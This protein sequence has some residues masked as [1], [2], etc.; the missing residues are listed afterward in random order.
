MVVAS[1]LITCRIK[2][3][4]SKLYA[5]LTKQIYKKDH[6]FHRRLNNQ[7]FGRTHRWMAESYFHNMSSM[8][9]YN[10]MVYNKI[11]VGM[12]TAIS[13]QLEMKSNLI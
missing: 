1:L 3:L 10:Q 2:N 7:Y 8:S 5:T 12:R 6:G 13:T 11:Y 9:I 4:N